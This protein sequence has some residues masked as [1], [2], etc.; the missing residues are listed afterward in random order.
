MSTTLPDIV[1]SPESLTE[2]SEPD[3]RTRV[4]CP[5]CLKMYADKLNLEKQIERIH[6]RN[7]A[8]MKKE[9]LERRR[10]VMCPVCCSRY[11]TR[12]V[13]K[14]HL[15]R[16]HHASSEFIENWLLETSPK[17]NCQTCEQHYLNHE[18]HQKQQI[19]IHRDATK[20]H[21]CRFCRR[22]YS[23]KQVLY[24]HQKAQH[25]KEFKIEVKLAKPKSYM[26]RDILGI[27]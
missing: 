6:V 11:T 24:R 10:T 16:I 15:Q 13:V 26:I 20:K 18:F 19:E 5:I 7:V 12:N 22:W 2:C 9:D 25:L 14:R 4:S 21:S 27:Q 1:A 23:S 8:E 3:K 17:D